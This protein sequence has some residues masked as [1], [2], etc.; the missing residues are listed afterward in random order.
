M[1]VDIRALADL[2]PQELERAAHILVQAFAEMAP[3][4]WPTMAEARQEVKEC[5]DS[6]YL[7]LAAM[8][9][10]EL[11][12]WIGA[13]PQYDGHVWELH[14][15]AV[16]V[17]HQRR[18]IGRALVQAL[19]AEVRLRDADTIILGTDD[20]AGWT[21]AAN[22]NL[23]GCVWQHIRELRNL[24]NHPFAF[25]QRLGFEVVGLLPDA[26]G[27]GKPDIMMAKSVKNT[28]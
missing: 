9:D 5:M 14:P 25:Y 7:A 18:G 1:A 27:P 28:R 26:N 12:G 8:D 6:Q 19:E 16:A 13:R 11:V 2:E 15:L 10:S 22:T 4:A 23:Y 3:A 17:D 24:K 21:S 20:E